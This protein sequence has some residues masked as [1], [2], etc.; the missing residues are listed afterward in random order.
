LNKNIVKKLFGPFILS[1]TLGLAPFSPE[2]HLFGKLRWILGGANGMELMDWF[3]FMFH[4]FPWVWL[5]VVLLLMLIKKVKHAN[6]S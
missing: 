6:Q 5:V 3:D 2:P 1:M 4:A